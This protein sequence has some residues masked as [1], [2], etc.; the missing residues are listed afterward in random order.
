[1]EICSFSLLNTFVKNKSDLW[2]C[3]AYILY[4]K[5]CRI[6]CIKYISHTLKCS[7]NLDIDCRARAGMEWPK[8]EPDLIAGLYT[9]QQ[10]MCMN[11]LSQPKTFNPSQ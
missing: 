10:L 6:M 3:W 4:Q 7:C 2:E 5:P 9:A 8:L 11:I 1:M